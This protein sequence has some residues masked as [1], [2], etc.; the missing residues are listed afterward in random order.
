M[1]TL[2]PFYSFFRHCITQSASLFVYHYSGPFIGYLSRKL[3]EE[4]YHLAYGAPEAWS[5]EN[6]FYYIPQR[7]IVTNVGFKY[8]EYYGPTFCVILAAWSVHNLQGVI[9]K[10]FK[11]RQ[12]GSPESTLLN[13]GQHEVPLASLLTPHF[14]SFKR[15]NSESNLHVVHRR[16]KRFSAS[17]TK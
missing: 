13:E 16:S 7:E 12:Q 8:G 6:L 5:F 15:Q 1:I 17:A 9:Y 11:H 3:Y 2:R 10:Q 4:Y 14:D